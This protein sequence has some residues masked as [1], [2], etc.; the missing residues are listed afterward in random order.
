MKYYPKN[1]DFSNGDK[2]KIKEIYLS[3]YIDY[4]VQKDTILYVD[5][6]D[7]S[8]KVFCEMGQ[9]G[10]VPVKESHLVLA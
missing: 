3:E 5:Y 7:T 6:Y 4:N 10:I 8:G 9:S 1:P 2:V